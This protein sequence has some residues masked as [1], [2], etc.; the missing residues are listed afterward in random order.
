MRRVYRGIIPAVNPARWCLPFLVP[1]CLAAAPAHAEDAAAIAG[2][3]LAI[4]SPVEWEIREAGHPSLGNIRFAY[5]RRPLETKIGDATVYSRAYFSCQKN[6]GMFAIEV[7]NATAPADPGGLQ[8]AREPRLVCSRPGESADGKLV[9]ED[10]LANWEINEKIGDALTRGLRA[11]PL[12]ECASIR[13]VQEV[14]LPQ[15]WAQKSARIEFDLLPY[16]RELDSI[17]AGC[18]ER[19]AYAPAP[20]ATRAAAASAAAA[21]PARPADAA[22]PVDASWQTARVVASGKTN[23][24]A[25]PTLQSAIVARLDPGALVLVQRTGNDWWRA[26][27]RSGAPFEGYIRHDRLVFR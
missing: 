22:R 10:L 5:I 17:F 26:K 7:A 16:D 23:V 18:G 24:R 15:G 19:S 13:V 25:G 3:A 11:F 21:K 8:P 6:R 12:R 2:K 27:A 20:S 1:A 9:Q 14:I 4:G